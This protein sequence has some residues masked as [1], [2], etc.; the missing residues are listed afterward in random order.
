MYIYDP[1]SRMV[2]TVF[3]GFVPAGKHTFTRDGPDA[4]GRHAK[5][6]SKNI[7]TILFFLF[8]KSI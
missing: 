7:L 6:N 8:K 2:K 3:K 5:N 4:S 1:M